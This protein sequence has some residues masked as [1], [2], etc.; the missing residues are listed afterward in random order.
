MKAVIHIED[1]IIGATYAGEGRHFNCGEWNGF[2]IIG[3][4]YELGQLVKDME[5]HCDIGD[6]YGTFIPFE[7]LAYPDTLHGALCNLRDRVR[8]LRAAIKEAATADW[9]RIKKLDAAMRAA[10]KA[11]IEKRFPW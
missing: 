3:L 6:R 10:V 1:M 7:M 4:R 11:V 5:Y 9:Q 8:E 2:A